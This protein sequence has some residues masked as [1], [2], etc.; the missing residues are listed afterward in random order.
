MEIVL[1]G[2]NHRTAP[3]ELRERVTFTSDQARRAASE[4]RSRGLL[5]ES[6]VL[7]TCNRSELYGVPPETS[8]ESATGLSSFLSEFHSIRPDVLNV[9][10]YQHYDRAAVRHLFRVSAGLDSLLLGEAE[11]LG[12][13]REAY[14][15]AHEY[16]ATGPVLNRLFQ[17]ALETGKRVRS[18]TELGTRPM[19]VAAA[20]VKLAERIFGKLAERSA[21]VLGAGTISEQVVSTLR[22]RGIAHLYVMNRSRDRAQTLATQFGA[23]LIEWGNWDS[24]FSA[25]DVVVSS[26]SSEEPVLTRAILESAMAARSNRALFVMDLGVPRNVDPAAADLYNLY[27]YNIENLT[28]IVEQN[29][30][31]RESEIPRAEAIVE[32]HI[33]KF[34]S[35]QASVELVGLVDALRS[36]IR[37]ER[38]AFIRARID[39]MNHLAPG[40]RE[41]V[42]NLM[43]ELLEKLLVE[44]ATRLR[45]EKELR[46]KIQNVEALRDLFLSKKDKP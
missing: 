13:V 28:E 36:R 20:G 9:A 32:E 19:S 17:G 27:V 21:L 26:V 6:L 8:H 30:A 4:L 15:F 35:W 46:R 39:G 10:L 12:Q 25:P 1:V 41:H 34:L 31:A 24:A 40:D 38:A 5:E 16:G 43:D 45:G 29:R 11:I 37:E 42:E 22:D 33:G 44:P 18:E 7:S 14:R 3:I 2:L 23:R